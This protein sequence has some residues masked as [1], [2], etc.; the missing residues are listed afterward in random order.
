M[1]KADE[2]GTL[3]FLKCPPFVNIPSDVLE[4]VEEV[5]G[6][7]TRRI[8][9]LKDRSDEISFSDRVQLTWD[10]YE[11]FKD[12]KTE[13][14]MDEMNGDSGGSGLEG[15][16]EGEELDAET[17]KAIAQAMQQAIEQSGGTF[18]GVTLSSAGMSDNP[19]DLEEFGRML[20]LHFDHEGQV[21]AQVLVQYQKP[22]RDGRYNIHLLQSWKSA[23]RPM[24]AIDKP[25]EQYVDGVSGSDFAE[26]YNIQSQL[27]M[28]TSN[29][30]IWRAKINEGS[31]RPKV[32]IICDSSGSIGSAHEELMQHGYSMY[33]SLSKLGFETRVVCHTTNGLGAEVYIVVDFDDVLRGDSARRAFAATSNIG[34]SANA[35]GFVIL[36]EGDLLEAGD[37]MVVI[38]DGQPYWSGYSGQRALQHTT[39]CVNLQRRKGIAVM[40]VSIERS[41]IE[42]NNGIYGE[43]WNIDA[44]TD[45]ST[46]LRSAARRIVVQAQSNKT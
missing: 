43:E 45:L 3:T 6:N 8:L 33:I 26:P 16:I 21:P 36:C 12:Q 31:K 18:N 28:E 46:G 39:A 4:K 11:M 34:M 24:A 37:I 5:Y 14:E 32:T 29:P 25:E 27:L 35:D 23:I 10:I 1:P 19:D 20:K 30:N 2:V 17:A 42:S 13:E 41:C 38:S 22:L 7:L 15:S 40:S 44:A 9:A